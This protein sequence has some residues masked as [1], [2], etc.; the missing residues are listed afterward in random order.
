LKFGGT[1]QAV[2]L[3]KL[4]T[5]AHDGEGNGA[6]DGQRWQ[7]WATRSRTGNGGRGDM[8]ARVR[9]T[10]ATAGEQRDSQAR[11]QLSQCDGNSW[12]GRLMLP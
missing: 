5:T 1:W 2:G 4:M 3:D 8:A 10:R 12:L 7:G 11:L 6:N 9:A